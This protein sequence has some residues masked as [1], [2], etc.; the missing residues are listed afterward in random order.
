MRYLPPLGC[1]Y[2]GS[3]SPWS[4]LV[5]GEGLRG[6]E[7]GFL[8]HQQRK[9]GA[10][11][12]NLKRHGWFCCSLAALQDP[13]QTL[14]KTGSRRAR[15]ILSPLSVCWTDGQT[16]RLLRLLPRKARLIYKLWHYR[17]GG[18]NFP[19]RISGSLIPLT[20]A[21]LL[22]LHDVGGSDT[23]AD[24]YS[25]RVLPNPERRRGG[26]KNKDKVKDTS[27]IPPSHIN[28]ASK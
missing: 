22:L 23:S 10:E 28:P 2:K 5:Y 16:Y 19:W 27:L 4:V 3:Q 11:P 24:C 26:K 12:L 8:P 15:L 6:R 21:K 1:F 20:L 7:T 18:L 17:A 14:A 9:T 13:P 25:C